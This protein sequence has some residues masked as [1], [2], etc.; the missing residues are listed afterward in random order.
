[1]TRRSYDLEE[2]REVQQVRF[3]VGNLSTLGGR[4]SLRWG[5]GV[6]GFKSSEHPIFHFL[7]VSDCV[8]KGG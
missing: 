5:Y 3:N 7:D 1:M 6:G 8:R 2:A 4:K